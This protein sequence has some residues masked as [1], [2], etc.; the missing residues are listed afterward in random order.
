MIPMTRLYNSSI[1]PSCSYCFFGRPAPDADAILCIKHGILRPTSYCGSF[2]YDPLKRK[3]RPRP[4]IRS[5]YSPE[6][7]KL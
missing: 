4:H 3:P 6:D 5:S 1:E 7:F 2:Q